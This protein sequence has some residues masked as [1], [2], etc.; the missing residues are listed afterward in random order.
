MSPPL[1]AS[2]ETTVPTLTVGI[3]SRLWRADDAPV[4]GEGTVMTQ[5]GT[6]PPQPGVTTA[7]PQDTAFHADLTETLIVSPTDDA[8]IRPF[9]FHAS[10][11]DLADL[12]RRIKA[13]RWP[14]RELVDDGTQ[15]VQLGLMQNLARYWAEDYDWRR[16]EAQLARRAPCAA[17][18]GCL[19][20][21][22][23]L[24]S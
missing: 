16:C 20:H 7:K 13:T 3:S 5:S 14:E 18:S 2:Y 6:T 11:E 1:S 21:L 12:K 10:D 8:S 17:R 4:S 22:C 24:S 23:H 15:G 9:E 19:V